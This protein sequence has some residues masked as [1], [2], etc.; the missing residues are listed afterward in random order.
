[1]KA[2]EDARVAKFINKS[3][4]ARVVI[5]APQEALATLSTLDTSLLEDLFIVSEVELVQADE[6]AC[7]VEQAQGEKCPRCWNYRK[8][9]VDERH[10]DVCERCASVLDA[11]G[12]KD[13]EE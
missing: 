9:G 1:M 8:L 4:E 2:L 6:L 7:T 5:A 13:D 10:P 3:Q 11:I 12:Y